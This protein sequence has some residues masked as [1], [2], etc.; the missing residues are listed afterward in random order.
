[1]HYSM[2]IQG[3]SSNGMFEWINPFKYR[4]RYI[5]SM[6]VLFNPNYLKWNNSSLLIRH[7]VMTEGQCAHNVVQDPTLVICACHECLG[8]LLRADFKSLVV[9]SLEGALVHCILTTLGLKNMLVQI[10]VLHAH[11]LT[12]NYHIT[13]NSLCRILYHMLLID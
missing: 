3:S 4:N 1:M 10:D 5:T 7:P 2:L 13:C 11:S 8:L 6:K 9:D 12:I